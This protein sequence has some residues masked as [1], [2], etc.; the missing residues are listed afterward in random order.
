M[1]NKG[2]RA[3][4]IGAIVVALLAIGV[5]GLNWRTVGPLLAFHFGT[6]EGFAHLQPMPKLEVYRTVLLALGGGWAI[7]VYKRTRRGQATVRIAASARLHDPGSRGQYVLLVR[8]SITNASSVLCRDLTAVATL[9][10]TDERDQNGAMVLHAFAEADPFANLL[11]EDTEDFINLEPGECIDTELP[12]LLNRLELL[13]LWVLIRGKQSRLGK[14]YDWNCLLYVDPASLHHGRT[15]QLTSEPAPAAGGPS[16]PHERPSGS[17][18]AGDPARPEAFL[19]PAELGP[20]ES[21]R[22]TTP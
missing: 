22:A 8:L 3:L 9:A 1:S 17:E 11:S 15:V 13:A 10:S 16:A 5:V 18:A 7:Y 2:R 12:F 19:G 21:G 20:A 4:W 14:R 6:A